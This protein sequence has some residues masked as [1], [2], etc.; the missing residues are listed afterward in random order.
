[1][2]KILGVSES[3]YYA[4][5]PLPASQHQRDDM[6]YLAHIRVE[7][8]R[9]YCACGLKRMTDELREQGV[10]IGERWVGRLMRDNYI[11]VVRTHNFKRTANSNLQHNIA[12]NLLD[13]DFQA[14]GPNQKWAGDISYHWTA[15]GGCFLR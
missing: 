4:L 8:K 10:T 3:C 13:G 1:M 6:V 11:Y 14:A 15:E 7:H 5:A 2:S 12:P 9:N